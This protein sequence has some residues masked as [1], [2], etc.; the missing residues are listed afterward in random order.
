MHNKKEEDNE[1]CQCYAWGKVRN[2]DCLILFDPGSNHNFI[3]RKLTSRL[4]IHAHEMGHALEADGAFDPPAVFV[5]PLIGKLCIHV[6]GY[7]DQEDFYI[8]PLKHQD[9]LLGTDR[10][11]V[12]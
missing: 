4:G 9:V 12:V 6:Q 3:S 11:S 10:K 7:V 2:Q 1:S 8:S 5:I